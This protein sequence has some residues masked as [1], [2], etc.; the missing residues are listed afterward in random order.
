L[1][2]A[3]KSGKAPLL[4]V[5]FVTAALAPT[6]ARA[7]GT[8]LLE[9]ALSEYDQGKFEQALKTLDEVERA[10]S[11]AG[12][13]A[14]A[15][16]Y[17]GATR[18]AQ[19]DAAAARVSFEAALRLDPTLELDPDRFKPSVVAIFQEVKARPRGKLAVRS[20]PPGAE[21]LVGGESLGTTPLELSLTAGERQLVVRLEGYQE[22]LRPA[23]VQAGQGVSVDVT[24]APRPS[25][26]RPGTRR[27]L[28]SFSLGGAISAR[29]PLAHMFALE[30]VV[31]LHLGRGSSGF[32]LGLVLQESFGTGK[33][34]YQDPQTYQV[35]RLDDKY[36]IFQLGLRLWWDVQ[37]TRR[38]GLYL[39]PSLTLAWD[40]IA[41]KVEDYTDSAH[42]GSVTPG[43]ELKL[44][45]ADRVLFFFRPFGLEVLIG[46]EDHLGHDGVYLRYHLNGG[47]AVTF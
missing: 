2:A 36:T 43:L 40:Y 24:L 1:A 26:V 28:A 44:L 15:R 42:T 18:A 6:V 12:E 21:V 34:D 4:A 31:G 3:L 33:V 20:T 37:L 25:L 38:T 45:L 32:A 35:Y 9:R 29:G 41:R 19:D 14:R 47:V 17:R 39:S 27:W 46:D 7:A 8:T 5:L 11:S 30:Q 23:L 16:L 13:R 10:A 22:Q